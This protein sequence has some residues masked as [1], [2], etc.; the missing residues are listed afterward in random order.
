MEPYRIWED[1]Q[2]MLGKTV[3]MENDMKAAITSVVHQDKKLLSQDVTY[4]S[5]GMGVGSAVMFHGEIIRGSDN[6]FGE[7]G[8]VIIHPDGRKCDWWAE[9]LCTD[10]IDT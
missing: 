7:V 10:N 8:H 1:G 5:I 2:A 9:R 4:L 3:Y 6:A